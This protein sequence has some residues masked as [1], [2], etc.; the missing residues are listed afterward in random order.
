MNKKL[1]TQRL[2]G[3]R[4]GET[5][6]MSATTSLDAVITAPKSFQI[7]PGT[8]P[9]F[10]DSSRIGREVVSYFH[11]PTFLGLSQPQA[12]SNN[13]HPSTL[14]TR[15]PLSSSVIGLQ[16]DAVIDFVLIS[17]IED[18]NKNELSIPAK[19]APYCTGVVKAKDRLWALVHLEQ[20]L[21]DPNFRAVE[22][23]VQ[24]P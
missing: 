13:D 9:Y 22:L 21:S 16:M 6:C 19:L 12:Q 15:D 11:L 4:L 7:I 2:I 1:V 3:Y 10:S 17:Q 14:I 23:P 18:A 8:K 5:Y 24:R 20:I